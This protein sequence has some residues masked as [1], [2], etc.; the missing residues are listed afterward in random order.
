MVRILFSV[1]NHILSRHSKWPFSEFFNTLSHKRSCRDVDMGPISE[2]DSYR[3]ATSNDKRT[4]PSAGL[5]SPSI[6]CLNR[7]SS[8]LLIPLFV[9][10]NGFLI[11]VRRFSR[12]S[13][14]CFRHS[15][16]AAISNTQ[17]VLRPTRFLE[18]TGQPRF[19]QSITVDPSTARSLAISEALADFC[20]R[21]RSFAIITPFQCREMLP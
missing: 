3:S 20:V 13:R 2:A 12:R 19:V 11:T 8:F 14:S 18:A 7:R 10:D 21:F 5:S 9:K 4:Q 17:R 15:F 6:M 1:W 16:T